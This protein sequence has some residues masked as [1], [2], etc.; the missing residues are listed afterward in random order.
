MPVRF[1]SPTHYQSYGQYHGVPSDT[2]LARYFYLDDF[3]HHLLQSRRRAV[4]R[5]GFALQLVT[6]RFLGTFIEPLATIPPPVIQHV[7][8][9]LDIDATAVDLNDYRQQDVFWDHQVIIQQS[10]GYRN[11]H[12]PKASLPFLRWLYWR[13]WLSAERPSV[14]FDL[15][16]AWL[17]EHKIVLP[18]VTVL[19]RLVA[20]VRDR[21]EQRSWRLL[22]RQLRSDERQRLRRLVAPQADAHFNFDTL[23]QLPTHLSTPQLNATLLRLEAMRSLGVDDKDFSLVSDNRLRSLADYALAAKNPTLRRLPVSRQVAV[24]LAGLHVLAIRTQ[25]LVLDMFTQWL[26][27]AVAKSKQRVEQH[28][29]QTLAAYDTAATLLS[30]VVQFLLEAPVNTPDQAL[31]RQFDRDTVAAAVQ[32]VQQMQQPEYHSYHGVLAQYYRSARRFL[33]AF[34]RLIDFNGLQTAQPILQAMHFL[35]QLETVTSP[36]LREAPQQVISKHWRAAIERGSAGIARDAYTLCVL[37]AL[38]AAL[39]RRDIYVMPSERWHDPR[40]FLLNDHRWQRLRPHI[41]HILDRDPE[42][43]P[44]WQRLTQQLN[45][46]YKQTEQAL[47]DLPDLRLEGD[48]DEQHPIVTQLDALPETAPLHH[49]RRH[50]SLRL[51]R[52]DLPQLLLEVH[53]L[54]GFAGAFTHISETQA[55]V[56]AFDISLCA[57]LLAEACNIGLEAVADERHEAL[58]LRRLRWVQANYIRPDTLITASD[59]LVNAQNLLRLVHYWGGGEVASADGLRFV[60]PQRAIHGGFNPKYFGSGRGITFF[61][62]MSDQFTGFHHIVIPGTLREALYTLDGLLEQSTD[63]QPNQLMTDSASYTD[64]VFGLFWLLGF[65]FSP[66]LVGIKRLR[67][68]RID[69]QA[70]YGDFNAVARQRV[71]PDRIVTHWDDLLRVAGSLKTGTVSASQLLRIFSGG[72]SDLSKALRDLGRIA[73][74]L[75]LLQYIQDADYRR[76]ILTQ[77]NYTEARHTLARRIC[78]GN[79]GEL[80]HGYRQGQEQQLGALA[81]V[82][83]IIVY[84]NSVYLDRALTDLLQQEPDVDLSELSRI[85]PLGYKHIRILGYYNFVPDD[86]VRQGTYRPLRPVSQ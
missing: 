27:E 60:V 82:L 64:W 77:L 75:H 1:L 68:W 70:D 49:L 85:T 72:K 53:R 3:D 66:R 45:I 20:Q 4:N 23:R 13:V 9:Q 56:D 46:A 7:A 34:L 6:L 17:I 24:L 71:K 73:K 57:V 2:Q 29:L 28:R 5:L 14:V 41:C 16:T 32:I 33:P 67:F 48:I 52:I 19:E 63:L 69:A 54:T 37:Q 51:P 59:W 62:F 35:R 47:V 79:R 65:Q 21:A 11:F 58:S 22:S 25:D 74:T 44:E 81:L 83:N 30:Q 86:V 18:G 76:R 8:T 61:N 36:D 55:R 15:A 39:Q 50:L 12:D 43:Q 42:P 80:K 38:E 78:Y 10:Y 26:R 84:W 40:Q 31:F